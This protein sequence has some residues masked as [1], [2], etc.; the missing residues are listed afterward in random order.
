M[1]QPLLSLEAGLKEQKSSKSSEQLLSTLLL[2]RTTRSYPVFH[3]Y[4]HELN[5]EEKRDS[6][7]SN[8]RGK[9]CQQTHIALDLHL[10]KLHDQSPPGPQ[11]CPAENSEVPVDEKLH[12]LA[13]CTHCP[14][15]IKLQN[16]DI[17]CKKLTNAKENSF[18]AKNEQCMTNPK[19]RLV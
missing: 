14:E 17:Q 16:L 9:V 18:L 3:L 1:I 4:S 5:V 8:D 13:V 11:K 19:Q 2:S 15:R 6:M 12:E 7:S 10:L